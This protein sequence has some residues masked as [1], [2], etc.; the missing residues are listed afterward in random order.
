MRLGSRVVVAVEWD[1]VRRVEFVDT[2]PSW[3]EVFLPGIAVEED[4]AHVVAVSFVDMQSMLVVACSSMFVHYIVALGTVAQEVA[5]IEVAEEAIAPDIGLGFDVLVTHGH[6]ASP[7]SI[8]V[9]PS[10]SRSQ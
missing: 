6:L 2:V 7:D 4:R 8:P 5:D 1:R 10:L 9:R 3:L